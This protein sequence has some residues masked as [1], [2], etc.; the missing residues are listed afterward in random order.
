L[1]GDHVTRGM[2]IEPAMI[3]TPRF[4]QL[5]AD[6]FG[7]ER[8]VDALLRYLGVA[9]M[10]LGVEQAIGLLIGASG[11]GKSTLMNIIATLAGVWLPPSAGRGLVHVANPDALLGSS[12]DRRQQEF[13]AM[14]AA[15]LVLLHEIKRAKTPAS[16]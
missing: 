10:G 9:L 6:Q 8:E 12:D 4:D 2:A 14:R 13:A 16:S 11:A 3:P 15:H 1:P 7:D 5:T